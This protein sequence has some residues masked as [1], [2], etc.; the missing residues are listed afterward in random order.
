MDPIS[1]LINNNGI[2]V[3]ELIKWLRQFP[4][5]GEVWVMTDDAHSSVAKSVWKLNQDDVVLECW[6]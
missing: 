6:T 5:H 3:G 2:T 4:D 1:P